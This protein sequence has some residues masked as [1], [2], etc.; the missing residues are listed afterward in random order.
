[1]RKSID[2]RRGIEIS[3]GIG[4]SSLIILFVVVA[5]VTLAMLS[6]ETAQATYRLVKK[7][8]QGIQIFYESDS[9][10]EYILADIDEILDRVEQEKWQEK[11]LLMPGLDVTKEGSPLRIDYEV[12]LKDK[13]A[14]KVVLAVNPS[15]EKGQSHY[16]IIKWKVENTEDWQ[17][18]E[19]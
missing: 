7:E 1:M 2:S 17:Y 14:L 5:L 19:E 16:R 9:K 4:T 8:V 13:Q 11:L 12:I 10:A 15:I 18:Q 6:L 3:M